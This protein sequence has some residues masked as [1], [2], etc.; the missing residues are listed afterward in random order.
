MSGEPY[1]EFTLIE[2]FDYFHH[3]PISIENYVEL[4]KL[5]Y[6]DH[7]VKYERHSFLID[8]I[9]HRYEPNNSYSTYGKPDKKEFSQYHYK[10]VI[11]FR[12]KSKL[13]HKLDQI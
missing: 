1:A 3:T 12:L 11:E 7:Y 9:E 2:A 8:S 10:I 6:P 13:K 5:K 4:I